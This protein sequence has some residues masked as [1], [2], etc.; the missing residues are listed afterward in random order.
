MTI[1]ID[2]PGG[3]HLPELNSPSMQAGIEKLGPSQYR[4]IVL[5]N[6]G[7]DASFTCNEIRA[8]E[9]AAMGDAEEFISLRT[10]DR[11][12]QRRD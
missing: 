2:I 5:V 7:Q 6:G 3:E 11:Y 9:F 8:T 1:P 4:G 12:K 10:A